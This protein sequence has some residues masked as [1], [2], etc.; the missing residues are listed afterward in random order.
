MFKVSGLLSQAIKLATK[1]EKLKQ[2]EVASEVDSFSEIDPKRAFSLDEMSSLIKSMS[3]TI[4]NLP[5]SSS[6]P[7]LTTLST[8]LKTATPERMSEILSFS[9]VDPAGFKASEFPLDIETLSGLGGSVKGLNNIAA[10]GCDA[11]KNALSSSTSLSDL[12][13][14]TLDL[15]SLGK[16]ITTTIKGAGSAAKALAAEA[17]APLSSVASGLATTLGGTPTKFSLTGSD[18]ESTSKQMGSNAEASVSNLSGGIKDIAKSIPPGFKAL[19]DLS[20]VT[21]QCSK[22]IADTAKVKAAGISKQIHAIDNK[23][24]VNPNNLLSIKKFLKT[25]TDSLNSYANDMNNKIKQANTVGTAKVAAQNNPEAAPK[26]LESVVTNLVGKMNKKDDA[27]FKSV[28]SK[29]EEAAKKATPIIK[30]IQTKNA[31]VEAQSLSA[32]RQHADK[33]AVIAAAKKH[34]EQQ[35]LYTMDDFAKLFINAGF[36]AYSYDQLDWIKQGIRIINK[37]PLS[38][39]RKLAFESL[40]MNLKTLNY[41]D[42]SAP[43]WYG[44]LY[45]PIYIHPDY[46]KQTF[47][48]SQEKLPPEKRM[49]WGSQWIHYGVGFYFRVVEFNL[50]VYNFAPNSR[51]ALGFKDAVAIVPMTNENKVSQRFKEI[52]ILYAGY[53]KNVELAGGAQE[54][55]TL[56]PDAPLLL[57]P[58]TWLAYKGYAVNGGIAKK[59]EAYGL[60][61]TFGGEGSYWVKPTVLKGIKASQ[62]VN[63]NGNLNYDAVN[64]LIGSTTV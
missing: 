8:E 9:N 23:V 28:V 32:G 56:F 53:K 58:E 35:R 63:K 6:S 33:P 1:Q 24:D 30:D 57:P 39:M 18:I 25:K 60:R 62:F 45:Y 40:K 13:V 16:S 15:N 31:S 43:F 46:D 51:R 36:D 11:V 48:L 64:E 19:Q 50:T 34:N 38:N 7:Q 14:S 29:S 44:L 2:S 26:A 4:S 10:G 27:K 20:S 3:T 49:Q 5:A 17:A 41:T 47:L 12:S 59:L 22:D 42:A 21:E 61:T 55:A 54:Y 52:E 37:M